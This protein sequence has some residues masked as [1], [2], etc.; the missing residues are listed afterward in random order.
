MDKRHIVIDAIS[1]E[2]L[3]I[4]RSGVEPGELLIIWLHNLPFTIK[5]DFSCF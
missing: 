1:K 5:L 2:G 3:A 4:I